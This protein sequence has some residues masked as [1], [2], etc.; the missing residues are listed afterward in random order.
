MGKRTRGSAIVEVVIAAALLLLIS[1]TFASTQGQ[2]LRLRRLA[3]VAGANSQALQTETQR[4]RSLPLSAFYTDPALAILQASPIEYYR[5]LALPEARTRALA[6]YARVRVT[7][8][9]LRSGAGSPLQV[10]V[11]AEPVYLNGL[12]VPSS[13][14]GISRAAGDSA[15]FARRVPSGLSLEELHEQM[16]FISL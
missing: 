11:L 8:T 16:S 10:T 15:A 1:G 3:E 5:R 4:L 2:Q 7:L 13:E 6:L 9:P 14:T 12:L